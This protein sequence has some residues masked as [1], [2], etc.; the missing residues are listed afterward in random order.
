[1]DVQALCNTV[2]WRLCENKRLKGKFQLYTT[3]ETLHATSLPQRDALGTVININM[4]CVNF[5]N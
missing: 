4:L 1:M 3:V 5:V 2:A